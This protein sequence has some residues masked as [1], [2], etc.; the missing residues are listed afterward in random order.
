[1]NVTIEKLNEKYI[2]DLARYNQ[3]KAN[4]ANY[5]APFEEAIL[6]HLAEE[7]ASTSIDIEN[8]RSRPAK[9][10]FWKTLLQK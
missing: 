4:T 7:L 2:S 9:K 1:M 5:R 8:F 6:E 3:F 10:P